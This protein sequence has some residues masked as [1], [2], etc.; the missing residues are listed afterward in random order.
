MPVFSKGDKSIL[1]IHIPKSAGSSVERIGAEAGWSESFS[2]RGKSL[3]DIFYFKASLQHLHA[4]A[5]SKL[6]YFDRFDSIFTIVRNPF[7]RFKSEYYWQRSQLITNLGVDD[8]VRDTLARYENDNHIYDNHIRPQVDFIPD[9]QG[10]E[11]FKLEQN[12]VVRASEIFNRLSP[13]NSEW[14]SWAK[15][16]KF[17]S[18]QDVKEKYS[19]KDL[20][21]EAK[22]RKCYDRIAD[23]YQADFEAFCYE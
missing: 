8:W 12:G 22:F 20:E 7:S 13:A 11:V 2:I 16:W 1:F 17:N 15:F 4:E 10:L 5:L 9:C 23:F 14:K 3:R 6:F 21:I 18:R 19:M